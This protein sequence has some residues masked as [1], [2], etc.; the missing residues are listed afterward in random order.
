MAIS[1]PIVDTVTKAVI[2]DLDGT[3]VN[4]EPTYQAAWRRAFLPLGIELRVEDFQRVMGLRPDE[5]ARSF[6][7]RY[8]KP[9]DATELAN[10]VLEDVQSNPNRTLMPG[11][12]HAIELARDV[13]LRVAVATAS[14]PPSARI[15]LAGAGLAHYFD[16]VASTDGELFGKPHPAVFLTAAARIGIDP[17]DCVVIEDAPN[18]VVAAKAARMGCIV[19][20]HATHRDDR[21]WAIADVV[22]ESLSDLTVDHLSTNRA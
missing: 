15:S 21:V 13:G 19:V 11:A 14:P 18:G 17:F 8:S 4:T 5:T 12:V 6:L 20:P 10:V 2:F 22:L 7:D 3:L 1:W 16:V 9:G